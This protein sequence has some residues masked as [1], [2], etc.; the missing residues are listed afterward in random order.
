M[1]PHILCDHE[2][3]VKESNVELIA[4]LPAPLLPFPQPSS[5]P[6]N[7]R[8]PQSSSPNRVQKDNAHEGGKRTKVFPR[9]AFLPSRI[10]VSRTKWQTAMMLV[11]MMQTISLTNSVAKRNEYNKDVST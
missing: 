2:A 3:L 5:N 7:D 6:G 10:R 9:P 11:M 4:A 8:S 1:P